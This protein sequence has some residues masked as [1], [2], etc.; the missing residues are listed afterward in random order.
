MNFRLWTKFVLLL[1]FKFIPCYANNRNS[2]SSSNCG[3][4]FF[5]ILRNLFF[6][7]ETHIKKIK[8]THTM[9]K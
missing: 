2:S 5:V 1:P 7:S 4:D 3:I 6:F 9:S 8:F